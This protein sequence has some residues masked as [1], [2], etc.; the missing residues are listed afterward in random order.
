MF[1]SSIWRNKRAQIY[2]VEA[3]CIETHNEFVFC[4]KMTLYDVHSRGS[5][6][7]HPWETCHPFIPPTR[8]WQRKKKKMKKNDLA[9]VR[10]RFQILNGFCKFSNFLTL[11]SNFWK[12]ENLLIHSNCFLS[13]AFSFPFHLATLFVPSWFTRDFFPISRAGGSRGYGKVKS[14]S[15]SQ[16]ALPALQDWHEENSRLPRRTPWVFGNLSVP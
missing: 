16:W 13:F 5:H 11:W 9:S 15:V 4:S 14:R 1:C 8:L 6:R 7:A 2:N 10:H 12:F 3:T